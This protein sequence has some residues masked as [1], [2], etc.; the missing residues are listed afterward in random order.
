MTKWKT[1]D[2]TVHPPE[3]HTFKVGIVG[4]VDIDR[5]DKLLSNKKNIEIVCHAENKSAIEYAKEREH[6]ITAYPLIAKFFRNTTKQRANMM[7]VYCNAIVLFED[8]EYM[9]LYANR[10]GKDIR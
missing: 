5:L 6:I 3:A 7:A 1:T 8:C 9:R 2:T 10:Y 4:T